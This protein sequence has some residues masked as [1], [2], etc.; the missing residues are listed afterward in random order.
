M[1]IPNILLGISKASAGNVAGMETEEQQ[2][3]AS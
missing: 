2:E 1:G 3:Y